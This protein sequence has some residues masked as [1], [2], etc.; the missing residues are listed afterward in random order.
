MKKL[1]VVLII[2]SVFQSC[3]IFFPHIPCEKT[4]NISAGVA[5]TILTGDKTQKP[6]L[7]GLISI[8]PTIYRMNSNAT[9]SAGLGASLQGSRYIERNYSGKLK[10][11]YINVP[12]LINYNT[13]HRIYG[14]IGI[15]P[16]FL[17][18][19]RD[20]LQQGPSHSFRD[21]I[22]KIEFAVPLGAGYWISDDISVGIRTTFGITNMQ[23]WGGNIRKHNILIAVMGR[24]RL[25]WGDQE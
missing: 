13:N 4:V 17:L 20:R 8:E 15:Q 14:E 18:T 9:I 23:N 16:G 2:A 10:M 22:K 5:E 25:N 6:A 19:A 11:S 7:G 12:L 3:C 1:F 21:Y 24:Y